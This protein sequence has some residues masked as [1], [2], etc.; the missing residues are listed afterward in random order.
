[1]QL[2]SRRRECEQNRA[3]TNFREKQR[4]LGDIMFFVFEE[5]VVPLV[6]M[7]FYVTTTEQTGNSTIY[8]RK[9]DWAIIQ[10]C[11]DENKAQTN[12]EQVPLGQEPDQARLVSRA[13]AVQQSEKRE[14]LPGNE[15]NRSTVV[16]LSRVSAA[17][18]E[19]MDPQ[20]AFPADVTR[21]DTD[22]VDLFNDEAD[23]LNETE[24]P[25]LVIDEE[26]VRWKN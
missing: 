19:S 3:Q 23:N 18:D 1:M 9:C 16:N 24:S 21:I 12:F 26:D 8:F 4:D 13:A 22:N 14:Q 2:S 11:A 7:H 6:K 20:Y 17:L 5:L 25:D 15:A 10:R